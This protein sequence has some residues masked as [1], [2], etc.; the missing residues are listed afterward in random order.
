[1]MFVHHQSSQ[2]KLLVKRLLQRHREPV[3]QS[4]SFVALMPSRLLMLFFVEIARDTLMGRVF[5][6][7]LGDLKTA[8]ED[9]AFRKFSLRSVCYFFYYCVRVSITTC[10]L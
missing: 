7:S 5:E 9:E 2:L 4:I 10:F 3:M 8:S 1:M 6:V